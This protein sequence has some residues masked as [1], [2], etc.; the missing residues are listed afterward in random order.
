[1]VYMCTRIVHIAEWTT[2]VCLSGLSPVSM[3]LKY[4]VK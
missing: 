3:E 1:M 2:K 4:M